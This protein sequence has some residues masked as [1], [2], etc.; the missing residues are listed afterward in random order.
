MENPNEIN[1]KPT[2]P[3]GLQQIHIATVEQ[4]EEATV[5]NPCI[6][7]SQSSRAVAFVPCAHYVN[8]LSCGHG[9]TECPVCQSKIMACVRIYE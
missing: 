1:C 8:C 4:N 9:R 7:C 3:E 6:I 2:S 5:I